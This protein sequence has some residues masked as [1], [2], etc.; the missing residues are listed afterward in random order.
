MLIMNNKI[1]LSRYFL[2]II[3]VLASTHF[4]FAQ[5]NAI[6]SDIANLRCEFL[7]NPLGI[8]KLQPALSWNNSDNS[9]GVVQ[10]SYKILVATTEDLLEKNK[11]DL[12]DS[13]VII[14][15]KSQ[16]VIYKGKTLTSR[17]KCYWKVELTTK[18]SDGIVRKVVSKP[19]WWEMGLLNASDW[20]A[21][22]IQS[23]VCQPVEND[24]VSNWMKMSLIP[25]E[26]NNNVIMKDQNLWEPARLKGLE[27]LGKI[28]PVPAF[29]NEFLVKK[30]IKK[31]RLY[32][33]G[34]GF[35]ESFI[36]GVAVSSRMHDPSVTFYGKRG[37]YVTHDVTALM[38]KGNNVFTA[39][40]GGG[41][42]NEPVVWGDGKVFGLPSVKAQIEIEYEDGKIET[43]ATGKEW[44]TAIGPITKSHYYAGEVYDARLAKGWLNG[45]SNAIKWSEVTVVG[46]LVPTLVSQLVE[47][48]R[49]IQR[50][51]PVAVTQPRPGI[52]VYDFGQILMG[53]VE[54]NVKAK[55]GT[56]IT[57]RSAEW[58]WN[59]S[60]QGPKFISNLLYYDNTDL[61]K[62]TE[63]MIIARPRGQ[64][65]LSGSFTLK[66]T[67]AKLYAQVGVP[68][69]TYVAN[70]DA[71]GENWRPSFTNHAFRYIEVQGLDK[72]PT[73]DLLTGLV[74]SSDEEI[75][76]EFVSANERFNNFWEASMNST[77]F[78]T[79]GMTWDNGHERLQSQVYHSWSAP[80]AAYMLWYPNLWRKVMED[81]RLSNSIDT[82]K[83]EFGMAVYG[84]RQTDLSPRN[85]V[86]Q[87]VNIELP[88][89]YH[90]YYG[91][92][93]E[94]E[95]QYPHMKAFIN[96]FI[97][98]NDGVILKNA[99]MG[100]WNDHFYYEM[101]KD[102]KWS[103]AW[104]PKNMISIMLYE[105]TLQTAA[106]AKELNKAADAE[107]FTVLASK[108]KTKTNEQWYNKET[109]TYA[110]AKIEASAASNSV[111][112]K[113]I[114]G[115]MGAGA[116]DT[117]DNSTGWH[118]MMAMAVAKGIAPEEDVDAIVENCILDMKK[119]YNSHPSTGHITQQILYDV[120]VDHG[121]IE[122]TYDMMNATSFPSFTWMLQ[123]GNKTIPEGPT[124]PEYLPA[125]YSGYQNEMQEPARWF[126]ESVCGIKV[127][128]K[129]P[130][131]K[132][133]TLI[134][135]F[136]S[137][138]PF[139][140]LLT[141]TPYGQAESSWVQDGGVITWT[142]KIPANS[143]ATATIPVISADQITESG[144][145]ISNTKG[146]TAK[147]K[148]KK[149]FEYEL[150]SGSYVFKFPAP[151]NLPS[152]LSEWK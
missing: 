110:G 29:R 136:P 114:G 40:I 115:N 131:F 66:E 56:Q 87:S 46:D 62:R 5:S 85:M 71:A 83:P 111:A 151:K 65:Y 108:L 147:G 32:T 57:M 90:N 130:G 89:V 135:H 84:T 102:G 148:S 3:T 26:V 117:V 93:R 76:G 4:L 67:T 73:L 152:R 123:S 52:Y 92:M 50:I 79:H 86:T 149:G 88:M 16:V 74:I 53:T 98:N 75:I 119:H 96:A 21:S 19:S 18:N 128:S 31:A 105:Y 97:P 78:S 106:I 140:K 20:T 70:G 13:G 95:M 1:H 69:L 124:E 34:L 47:P 45:K 145:S 82:N 125:R 58:T 2:L 137:K 11:A 144:N 37:A 24:V 36:N 143:S 68:T 100:A 54:L 38:Q 33:S 25:Q 39:I 109:K 118:G 51:K 27:I 141:A 91:D 49:V 113:V 132:H 48:E 55:S 80:F 122:T 28:L 63:G 121:M 146:C 43:I 107:Y 112:G 23:P 133:F 17:L 8:D 103:P 127:D 104:D 61:T 150:G 41:W 15:D 99:M 81:L 6:V 134:P 101:S 22:W 30:K 14:S 59:P 35:Q 77:R 138:L 10:T 44:K 139:A 116:G 72:E 60:K 94:I 12:W 120:L 9:R 7:Q 64:S 42:W 142:V 126:T 129:Q